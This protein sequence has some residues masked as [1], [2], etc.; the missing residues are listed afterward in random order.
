M[1]VFLSHL[2]LCI[3]SAVETELLSYLRINQ[4]INQSILHTQTCMHRT[5]ETK[6]QN[7]ETPEHKVVCYAHFLICLIFMELLEIHFVSLYHVD[8]A[9]VIVSLL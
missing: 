2:I 9:V 3:T 1:V 7:S 8:A 6:C 4:S 5:E